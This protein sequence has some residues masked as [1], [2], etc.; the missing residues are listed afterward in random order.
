M[1]THTRRVILSCLL[2]ALASLACQVLASSDSSEG[3]GKLI[4][5]DDFSD[6]ES[7]W[8]QVADPRGET[9]YADGMY[10]ILVNQPNMDIWAA[11]HLAMADVI[12]EVDAL[13]IGGDRDNRF[14][15]ICRLT[16]SDSFYAFFISSDGYY[17]IGKFKSGLYTLLG[18]SALKL[19]DSIRLGSEVN[20]LRAACIG[21]KLTLYVDGDRLAQVSD[22]EL[23]SGD[24]GLIAGTYDDAG[25]D[26]RFDNFSLFEP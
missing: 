12:I 17:G 3:T 23:T 1:N 19:S 10:R 7:G 2:L 25:V 4:F 11:P 9:S 22:D 13:K 24:A 15:I 18:A 14:G 16:G 21:E 8:Q 20:H 26:I 6:P 5:K